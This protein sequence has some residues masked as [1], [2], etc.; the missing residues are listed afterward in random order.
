MGVVHAPCPLRTHSMIESAKRV[1]LTV[2]M[3]ASDTVVCVLMMRVAACEAMMAAYDQLAE[4]TL[5]RNL[6]RSERTVRRYLWE[7]S[8]DP[9]LWRAIERWVRS[10]V[11][12]GTVYS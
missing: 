10:D 1:E 2:G 4:G 5:W 8:A 9:V 7:A 3:S 12:E 11:E 6:V